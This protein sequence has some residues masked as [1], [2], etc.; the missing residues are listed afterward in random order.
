MG[1]PTRSS[2]IQ[3][4]T[5]TYNVT[6]IREANSLTSGNTCYLYPSKLRPLI[7][8]VT[9]DTFLETKPICVT[10]YPPEPIP[11]HRNLTIKLYMTDKPMYCLKTTTNFE[12]KNVLLARNYTIEVI[13]CKLQSTRS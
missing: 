5:G 13:P 9:N 11:E 10:Y 12:F 2:Q 3:T 4:E 7:V 1:K 8:N 6:V